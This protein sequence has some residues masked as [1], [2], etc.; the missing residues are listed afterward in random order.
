MSDLEIVALNIITKY[1]SINSDLQLFRCISVIDSDGEIERSVQIKRKRK[2]FPYIKKNR[3]T[4]SNK[5]QIFND[6]FILDPTL[7]KIS[8]ISR[9]NRSAICT[10]DEIKPSFGYC[11]AQKSI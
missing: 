7:I 9:A 6:V 1:T 4:L 3:E 10:T 5:F 8:K 11:A 2:F